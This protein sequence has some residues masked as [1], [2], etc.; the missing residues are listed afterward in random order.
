MD[1]KCSTILVT[2]WS[3]QKKEH[4]SMSHAEIKSAGVHGYASKLN[5]E[6]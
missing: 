2:F 6:L 3:L 4:L 5:S 1:P